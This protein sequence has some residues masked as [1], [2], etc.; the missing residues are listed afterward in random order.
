MR[1]ATLDSET[2]LAELRFERGRLN[3]AIAAVEASR[4][5]CL[6]VF[7]GTALERASWMRSWEAHEHLYTR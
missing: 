5:N 1:G 6:V 4:G 7:I 2:I 3:R